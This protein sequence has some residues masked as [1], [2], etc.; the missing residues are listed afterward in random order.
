MEAGTA[1]GR[2]RRTVPDVRT[3]RLADL[4]PDAAAW[5]AALDAAVADLPALREPA[6]QLGTSAARLAEAL[7]HRS[8]LQR[9]LLHLFV[10]GNEPLDRTIA[11]MHQVM[12]AMEAILD[13]GA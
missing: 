3:W 6:G 10:T 8:R 7:E 13:A 9:T 2:D 5:R 12:D 11:R 4:H 1:A